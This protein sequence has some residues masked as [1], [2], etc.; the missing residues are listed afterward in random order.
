MKI[1]NE[2]EEYI[3]NLFWSHSHDKSDLKIAELV[4]EKLIKDDKEKD[5]EYY[6]QRMG[7]VHASS[8]YGCLRGT[9][10]N[11]LCHKPTAEVE[12]RKLGVFKAGNLFEDFIVEA[13]GDRVIGQQTEYE[14]KYK[15]ITLVG[16]SDY[17][18]DDNGVIRI[19]ENK[20][21]HSDAF[22]HRQQEGTL[23]QWHNQIQLQIYLWLERVLFG[24]EVQGIFSYVSKDDCTVESCPIKFNQ[25]II[26]EVVIPSLEIINTAY[27]KRLPMIAE[28][29]RLKQLY[30]EPN[31]GEASKE[32]HGNNIKEIWKQINDMSDVPVPDSAVH[33]KAKNQWQVNWLAK[34][35]NHH[36]SCAGAGWLLEAQDIV[37]R[38]NLEIKLGANASWPH[39]NKAKSEISVAPKVES[40]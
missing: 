12:A 22:W 18:I 5:P 11:A 38:K 4:N 40:N 27:E 28:M 1:Y 17:R 29:R 3:N 35:C 19:G 20:S 23:I 16:R 39:L 26:D 31:I 6:N 33:N 7:V 9:L 24:R 36:S 25:L 34:Y 21:V 8:L 37:K 15:S 32:S 30:D 14:Y 2:A 13:L 10:H